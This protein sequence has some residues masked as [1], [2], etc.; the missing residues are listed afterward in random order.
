[1]RWEKELLEFLANSHASLA[2][3]IEAK[4]ALDDELKKRIEE[5][6]KSF[7]SAFQA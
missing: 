7:N 1:M 6:V 4:K 2:S 5:V 3:D